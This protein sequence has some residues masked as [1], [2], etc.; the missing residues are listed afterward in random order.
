V[1]GFVPEGGR[2]FDLQ[3]ITN[4]SLWERNQT[5][6]FFY[7]LKGSYEHD[8]LSTYEYSDQKLDIDSRNDR[9]DIRYNEISVETRDSILLVLISEIKKRSPNNLFA[10]NFNLYKV[11]LKYKLYIEEYKKSK[12]KKNINQPLILTFYQFIAEGVKDSDFSSYASSVVKFFDDLIIQP[13]YSATVYG[14]K[15]DSTFYHEEKLKYGDNMKDLKTN[16]YRPLIYSSWFKLR[17]CNYDVE[18]LYQEQDETFLYRNDDNKNYSY[19]QFKYFFKLSFSFEP[20]LGLINLASVMIRRADYQ[21][22][23]TKFI[24][25]IEI[26]EQV[27]ESLTIISLT[28]VYSTR[29]LTVAVTNDNYPV[30]KPNDT[31]N[32]VSK[33]SFQVMKESK[34]ASHL[35]MLPLNSDRDAIKMYY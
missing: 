28:D 4:Y 30:T 31:F 17:S 25:R 26:N 10:I 33:N 9:T 3:T 14:I 34:Y 13:H 7:R 20:N 19:G 12:K 5:A 22:M 29:I 15:M 1:K 23:N 2:S 21:D 6:C 27:V 18:E 11:F 8:G 24:D 32:K 16:W 35:M